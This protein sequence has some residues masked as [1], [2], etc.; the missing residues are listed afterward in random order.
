MEYGLIQVHAVENFSAPK[1]IK[2]MQ[3][4]LGLAGYYRKFI[5]N[6]SKIAKLLT[7]LTKK[8][9]KFSWT[10][11]KQN[12][13][14]LLKEKLIRIGIKLPGFSTRIFINDRRD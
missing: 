13:F 2:D 9:E 14:Q 10:A 12:S 11:E 6:F 7:K 5:E 3:F 1:K 8:G 4:F